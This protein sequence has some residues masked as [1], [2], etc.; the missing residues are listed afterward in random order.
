MGLLK[1]RCGNC[2][3]KEYIG[4]GRT[5]PY[6]Y[7]CSSCGGSGQQAVVCKDCGS[8]IEVTSTKWICRHGSFDRK[9]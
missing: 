9:W 5:P 3:G 4:S 8:F 1:T 6:G 2:G 7:N